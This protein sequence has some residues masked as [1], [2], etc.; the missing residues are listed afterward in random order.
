MS[1]FRAAHRTFSPGAALTFLPSIVRETL[2][3]FA[4]TL[5]LILSLGERIS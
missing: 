5:P 4:S 2:L 1:L 3:T